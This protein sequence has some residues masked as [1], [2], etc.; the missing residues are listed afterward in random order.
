MVELAVEC[1]DGYEAIALD[2]SGN[3]LANS[4]TCGTGGGKIY[5]AKCLHGT[6]RVNH[7]CVPM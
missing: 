7:T 6:F 2:A 4:V 1:G 5:T 3:A